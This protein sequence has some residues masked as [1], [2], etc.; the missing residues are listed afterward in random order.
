[1]TVE[2]VAR[3]GLTLAG[4]TANHTDAAMQASEA[5]IEALSARINAPLLA[6]LPFGET[7]PTFDAAALATLT[8]ACG[9]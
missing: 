6:R 7:T 5:N 1:L 8:Q 3:D 2:A 4:W 9:G